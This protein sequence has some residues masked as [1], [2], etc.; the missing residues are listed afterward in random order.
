MTETRGRAQATPLRSH[1]G[2][3]VGA[4][5]RRRNLQQHAEAAAL[6]PSRAS[7]GHSPS[8]PGITGSDL[9]GRVTCVLA[10]LSPFHKI[11]A[12]PPLPRGTL[13]HRVRHVVDFQ[14]NCAVL[15]VYVS[16]LT[17]IPAFA[18]VFD[19]NLVN[20]HPHM[21]WIASAILALRGCKLT[22]EIFWYWYSQGWWTIT[23]LSPWTHYKMTTRR[24]FTSLS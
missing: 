13:H 4:N 1:S 5:F 6:P 17:Y 22:L 24:Q 14:Q 19:L 3:A 10:R 9:P 8:S 23:I 12:N 20:L 2:V 11:P 15:S 21:A 18:S 16:M 7:P